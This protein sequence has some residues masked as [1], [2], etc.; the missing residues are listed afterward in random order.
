MDQIEPVPP[1]HADTAVASTPRRRL[2]RR[3]RWIGSIVAILGLILV[4]ALAWYLTHQPKS[5][6]AGAPFAG[7]GPGGPGGFGGPPGG[8][9]GGAPS[10][11]GVAVAR[12]A[13]I[14][15]I[16]EALGTVIPAAN[17]TVRP[18]V[19]G[20]ITQVLFKEGQMVKKGDLLAT[21]DPQPFQMALTQATGARLR[22][23]AQLD[24]ARVTLDRYRTLLQQDSIARQDVD[25]QDSLVKQL[26]GTVTIDRAN[27]GTARLNLGYA[28]IVAPVAGRVGL[29][30]VDAGNYIGAGDANGIVVITQLAPIDVEFAIPQD[31]VPEIQAHM[32]A[33]TALPVGAW[34]RARTRRL[35][36]GTFSTL[37]NQIDT[38]TGTVKA[39]ARFANTDGLLFPNQFVNARL[40]LRVV[41]GAVVV[42]VTALRHGPNGDFVYVVKDD[43]TV[44]L[45]NVTRGQAGVDDVAIATGL[46]LGER[47]VTEGGD[48]LK[49]GA[50]VQTS[51]ER[52]ANA[53]SG[54][55]S[56]ARGRRGGF[57]ASGASG[58]GGARGERGERGD[59]GVAAT[60]PA[61]TTQAAPAAAQTTAQTTAPTAAQ[62][63]L[64]TPEQR[65][66]MLDMVKDDPE[67]LARRQQFLAALDKG[68]PAAIERWQQTV[69]R[70]REGGASGPPR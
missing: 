53:A 33:G 31:N 63:P 45:R 38:T 66:R 23:E 37:D 42:P 15:V 48:R 22:D 29:R 47:V 34:D 69:M 7:G 12:R 3:A 40:L 24:A 32:K 21:I 20:V 19:S 39:K 54:A 5:S 18:Q 1:L 59:R 64:P 30:V 57:G 16:L 61:A 35:D 14:P 26:V 50:R 44:E 67:Q 17:V 60:A 46:E 70:R 41:D 55:A 27:E 6:A 10:T 28:R 62:I 65:Q 52:P 49:D 25:T 68:D 13:D 9:R 11:V 58:A 2:S 43:R 51:V 36:A 8:G 56:G 4:A